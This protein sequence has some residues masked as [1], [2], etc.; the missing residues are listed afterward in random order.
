MQY[1]PNLD[2][3]K[4]PDSERFRNQFQNP[5]VSQETYQQYPQMTAPTNYQPI[6]QPLHYFNSQSGPNPQQFRPFIPYQEF[7]ITQPPKIEINIYSINIDSQW[8]AN[9]FLQPVSEPS[10]ILPSQTDQ[11]ISNFKDV[12]TTKVIEIL[13]NKTPNENIFQTNSFCSFQESKEAFL[14]PKT[15]TTSQISQLS[16]AADERIE[17]SKITTNQNINTISFEDL[18]ANDEEL[19]PRFCNEKEIRQPELAVSEVV[20]PHFIPLKNLRSLYSLLIKFFKGYPIEQSVVE[21]LSDAELEIL[22]LII[23]RK[24]ETS[25]FSNEN[26]K[27]DLSLITNIL[28]K[29]QTKITAKR[30]EESYKFI[31][32][33]AFKYMKKSFRY[34][35]ELKWPKTDTE[36][37]FYHHYF[38]EEANKKS[39]PLENYIYPLNK[40]DQFGRPRS[41]NFSYFRQVCQSEAFVTDFSN[42]LRKVLK[43]DYGEEIER[44]TLNVLTKWDSCL[45]AG[46][47]NSNLHYHKTIPDAT[48]YFLKNKRCKIPWT[49]TEV[50]NAIVRVNGLFKKILKNDDETDLL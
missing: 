30:P 38:Q 16:K 13:K 45:S 49:T 40:K 4:K 9:H 11:Q 12:L 37:Q 36:E 48:K 24:Y 15:N 1:R 23:R 18:F 27:R 17:K 25:L 44:K 32:T 26:E 5:N 2:S 6:P 29:F 42:Y 21:L 33:R 31:F 22:N 35:N 47:S 3:E 41:L 14:N 39:I 50:R 10:S 46:I 43:D 34:N 28:I 19:F 8:L 20:E 7:P